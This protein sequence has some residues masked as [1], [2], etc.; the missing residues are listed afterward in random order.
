[1]TQNIR[2]I[3]L[4]KPSEYES[5]IF[6]QLTSIDYPG[7]DIVKKQLDNCHVTV[8]DEF[9][10]LRLRTE[11]TEKAM[12]Q[13]RVPIEGTGSDADGFLIHYSLHIVNGF[14]DELEI[15]KDNLAK[16]IKPILPQELRLMTFS[17]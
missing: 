2:R 4:R 17:K 13:T 8:I 9:G 7:K 10:S 12:V 1:M 15:Y 3:G 11:S 14:V 6:A 16:I 5:A